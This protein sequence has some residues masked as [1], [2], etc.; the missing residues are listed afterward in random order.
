[1]LLLCYSAAVT[2]FGDTLLCLMRQSCLWS[3]MALCLNKT[4]IWTDSCNSLVFALSAHAM[5]F[6]T[7]IKDASFCRG[8]GIYFLFPFLVPCSFPPADGWSFP[9]DPREGIFP[10]VWNWF[11]L[12]IT[13]SITPHFCHLQRLFFPLFKLYFHNW[14]LLSV[15]LMNSSTLLK[16]ESRWN[17]AA[18][19]LSA[20]L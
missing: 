2:T 10:Q 6:S 11:Q 14:K 1:M 12:T 7:Y 5:S 9:S 4:Q 3:Q 20:F 17:T 15:D 13:V 16:A 18:F 8:E 19:R